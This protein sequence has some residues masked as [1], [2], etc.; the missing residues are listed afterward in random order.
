MV[1]ILTFNKNVI[2]DTLKD[3][4][5]DLNRFKVLSILSTDLVLGTLVINFVI[6]YHHLHHHLKQNQ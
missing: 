5:K 6:T 4:N 3:L 2:S 1:L